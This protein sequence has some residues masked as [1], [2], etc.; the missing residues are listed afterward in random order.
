MTAALCLLARALVTNNRVTRLRLKLVGY[1]L[2]M[3][4][5]YY[6]TGPLREVDA[7][8]DARLISRVLSEL[9]STV[10]L[11]TSLQCAMQSCASM[12]ITLL[13]V[14]DVGNKSK[15]Y[16]W[17]QKRLLYVTSAGTSVYVWLTGRLMPKS[18]PR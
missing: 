4:C 9:N 7:A 17:I 18:G 5:S 10:E 13:T 1:Y 2:D 6:T 16:L 15:C 14:F 8:R 11:N 12:V 3:G